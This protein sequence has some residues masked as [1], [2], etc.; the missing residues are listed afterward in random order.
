MKN[1][2]RYRSK[3]AKIEDEISDEL[4]ISLVVIQGSIL[5]SFLLNINPNGIAFEIEKIIVKLFHDDNTLLL[6][7]RELSHLISKIKS[8]IFTLNDW[9]K[10]N[11]LLTAK[12]FS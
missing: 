3:S 2:F 8:G 11:C 9:C 1:Y 12:K 7:E 4:K 5:R 6:S 10:F